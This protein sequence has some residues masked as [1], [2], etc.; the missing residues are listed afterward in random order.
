MNDELN[1]FSIPVNTSTKQETGSLIEFF[2]P[3]IIMAHAVLAFGKQRNH[4]MMAP[5]R[6]FIIVQ[7]REILLPPLRN[8]SRGE[9][10]IS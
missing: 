2:T 1:M 3:R 9:I 7:M 10:M 8:A 4:D 5:S 6:F